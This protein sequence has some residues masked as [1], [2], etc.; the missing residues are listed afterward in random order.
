MIHNR[1]A[2][3]LTAVLRAGKRPIAIE[4]PVKCNNLLAHGQ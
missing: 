1:I 3:R 4:T 2:R